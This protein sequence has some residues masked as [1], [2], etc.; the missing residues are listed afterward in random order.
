M[1]EIQKSIDKTSENNPM[2]SRIGE[3]N[4]MF[5][6]SHTSE[7]KEVLSKANKKN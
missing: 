4:P 6:K 5:G 2:F 7:T 1:S 3:L